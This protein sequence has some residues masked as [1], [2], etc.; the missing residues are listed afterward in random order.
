MKNPVY[1]ALAGVLVLIVGAAEG[2]MIV[3]ATRHWIETR[4]MTATKAAWADA[5]TRIG[6]SLN[7]SRPAL[8]AGLVVVAVC[9]LGALWLFR[10]E[11]REMA[12]ESV[13]GPDRRSHVIRLSRMG[14]SVA[15]IARET[16]MAQ[17]AVRGM[18][19]SR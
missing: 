16:R 12:T 18:L 5:M 1:R 3:R 2:P 10:R 14:S 7:W 13:P 17:D 15:E 4:S 19:A 8:I 6:T 9:L 11:P